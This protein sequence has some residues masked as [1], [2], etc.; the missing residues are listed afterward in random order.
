MSPYIEVAWSKVRWSR[1]PRNG[2]CSSYRSFRN[3][4]PISFLRW[5]MGTRLRAR[6]PRNRDSIP[7]RD[8]R[9]FFASLRPDWFWRTFSPLANRRIPG[10]VRISRGEADHSRPP[11]TELNDSWSHTYTHPYIFMASC[12]IRNGDS[13]ALSM[14]RLLKAEAPV[15][16]MENN[17]RNKRSKCHL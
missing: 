15:L 3:L 1:W 13:F 2:F 14:T 10:A 8:K 7:N 9:F 11:S 17:K 12:L 16:V 5:T 4:R 6:K